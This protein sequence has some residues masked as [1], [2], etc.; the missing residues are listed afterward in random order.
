M[1]EREK[2]RKDETNLNKGAYDEVKRGKHLF[3]LQVE[4]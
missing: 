4:L 2:I 3:I 1:G